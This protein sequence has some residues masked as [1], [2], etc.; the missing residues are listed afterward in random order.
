M[1]HGKLAQD[2]NGVIRA[3]TFRREGAGR[4][5][6]RMKSSNADATWKKRGKKIFCDCL[7]F[8]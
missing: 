3:Q 5:D 8:Q 2:S 1:K 6:L 4:G 7:F